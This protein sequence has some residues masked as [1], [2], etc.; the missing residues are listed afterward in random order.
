MLKKLGMRWRWIVVIAVALGCFLLGRK[1]ADVWQHVQRSNEVEAQMS[2]L[3]APRSDSGADTS[4]ITIN[5]I[6]P[7]LAGASAGAFPQELERLIDEVEDDREIVRFLLCWIQSDAK[8][9]ADYLL[10]KNDDER[11]DGFLETFF[12]LWALQ[13]RSGAETYAQQL[14][15]AGDPL[16]VDF[17]EELQPEPAPLEPAEFLEG[18][19]PEDF[20]DQQYRIGEALGELVK[21]DAAR[22]LA[23]LDSMPN[24]ETRRQT[25]TQMLAAWSKADSGAA[26]KWSKTIKERGL[27]FK[28]LNTVISQMA[29]QDLKAARQ[30][31]EDLL[32]PFAADSPGGLSNYM[33]AR[34]RITELML[35]ENPED[36]LKWWEATTAPDEYY[37]SLRFDPANLPSDPTE[38]RALLGVLERDDFRRNLIDGMPINYGGDPGLWISEMTA[39][40][41]DEMTE[42]MLNAGVRK[43][44]STDPETVMKAVS[45]LPGELK[46]AG[47]KAVLESGEGFS[48]VQAAMDFAAMTK[49]EELPIEFTRWAAQMDDTSKAA[50]ALIHTQPRIASVLIVYWAREDAQ[51]ASQWVAAQEA[52]PGRDTA[53]GGLSEALY[54]ADPSSAFAWAVTIQDAKLREQSLSRAFSQ[55]KS[56][57][58]IAAREALAESSLPEETRAKLLAP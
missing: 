25:T 3:I 11:Y 39:L 21:T 22:A 12:E 57:D 43:W 32:I 10:P 28:A 53:A 41:A 38:F 31:Y 37:H 6:Y 33:D 34:A 9:G 30:A 1:I 20:D 54:Q 26:L 2:R 36:A 5:E 48:S 19:T 51:A 35:K 47:A 27:Q 55:W 14:A 15:A 8:A 7:K 46:V 45:D 42:K 13:D 40:P 16:G 56:L 29:T 18:L 58:P 23:F 52:G 4:I 44:M 24:D 49:V 50:D 17:L